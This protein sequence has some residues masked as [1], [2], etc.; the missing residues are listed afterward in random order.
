MNET[1]GTILYMV[2]PCYNE[3]EML[4]I[5]SEKLEEKLRTLKNA[6]RISDASR[7]VYVDDGSKDNTWNIIEEMHHN[8]KVFNG[9]KLSRNEGH[10]NALLAGLDYARNHADMIVSMDADLQDDIDAVDAMIDKYHAGA[11]IVYGVRNDR[12]TDSAFK[13]GTAQLFYKMMKIMGA[14]IVYNH[15]DFRLMSKRAVDELMNFKEVNLFLRG[16]VPLIGFKT[17]IVE[18]ERHERIAGE[19][20]YPLKKML[21]F[22]ID[23]VTSFSIKPINMIITA[24]FVC[25]LISVGMLIYSCIRHFTGDTVSGWTSLMT[26]IWA[27]GGLQVVSIGVV[28][29]YIGKVYLEVKERPRYIVDKYL[30]S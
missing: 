1:N 22:A 29:K 27:L 4:H 30:D 10:Q 13:R 20:K 6:G 28:G 14:E 9:V 25:F 7:V 3:E 23:G 26:S 19:S 15:A 21:S 24:G 2:V 18:Y 17:D 8:N 5:T 16:I 11:E 12:S